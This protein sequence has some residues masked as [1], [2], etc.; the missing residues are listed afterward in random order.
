MARVQSEKVRQAILTGDS[1]WDPINIPEKLALFDE[2]GNPINL[3]TAGGNGVPL[4]GT[5]GQILTKQSATDYDINWE[6]APV[7][8]PPGGDAGQILAKASDDDADAEWVDPPEGGGGGG[9]AAYIFRETFDTDLSMYVPDLQ[10]VVETDFEDLVV[11]DGAM[12]QTGAVD[13]TFHAIDGEFVNGI[14]VAKVMPSDTMMLS[15]VKWIDDE[16]WIMLQYLRH[17]DALQLYYT[18]GGELTN[19]VTLNEPSDGGP[20]YF[21]LGIDGQNVF[22]AAYYADPRSG[23]PPYYSVYDRIEDADAAALVDIPGRAG[24]RFGGYSSGFVDPGEDYKLLEHWATD[25]TSF[26][27]AGGGGSGGN[28]L[29][30]DAWKGEYDD[31]DPYV[32]GDVVRY[33]SSLYFATADSVVDGPAPGEEVEAAPLEPNNI[34]P[35]EMSVKLG[36]NIPVDITIL[37]SG[38]ADAVYFYFDVTTAGTLTFHKGALGHLWISQPDNNDLFYDES[39]DRTETLTQT[40]RYFAAMRLYGAGPIDTMLELIPGTAVLEELPSSNPWELVISGP[41]AA[42]KFRGVWTSSLDFVLGDVVIDTSHTYVLKV[43][44]LI[45]GQTRP[46]EEIPPEDVVEGPGGDIGTVDCYRISPITGD[47]LIED[48]AGGLAFFFDLL[49]GGTVTITDPMLSG[50]FI[51]LCDDSGTSIATNHPVPGYGGAIVKT[52]LTPGR[53][54][55]NHQDAFATPPYDMNPTIVLSDDAEWDF[56]D[57]KWTK[58]AVID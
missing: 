40:G 45:A 37:V 57:E 53:Y 39:D 32:A 6:N 4:G 10:Q 21:A 43:P 44:E 51:N 50:E 8:L 38:M 2:E 12:Y 19:L 52:G 25:L 20:L 5:D 30:G 14:M 54:F 31:D 33:A 11:E 41:G 13:H 1:T 7:A 22:G 3:Q 49:E 16:N 26:L 55:L 27:T 58:I 24:L 23:A 15:V 36:P 29:F 47:R 34:Y 46:S 9:E 42:M 18:V 48:A 28:G 56:G 35:S 17:H